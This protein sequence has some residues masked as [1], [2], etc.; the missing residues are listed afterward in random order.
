MGREIS[1]SLISQQHFTGHHFLRCIDQSFVRV[2]GNTEDGKPVTPKGNK[3]G[4]SVLSR[5]TKLK[6]F[7][8]W[9]FFVENMA[10][11]KFDSELIYD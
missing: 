11:W 3:N 1:P 7:F 9:L 2:R 8:K 5:E 6:I 4:V 10:S